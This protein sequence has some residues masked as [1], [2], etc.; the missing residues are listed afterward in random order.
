[1]VAVL[2]IHHQRSTF[3]QLK[4]ELGMVKSKPQD[5]RRIPQNVLGGTRVSS[6]S[7]PVELEIEC[8]WLLPVEFAHCLTMTA[9]QPVF[10][11]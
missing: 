6:E 4:T 2:R 7:S 1:M 9:E 8:L 11:P 3:Q 5:M 10:L